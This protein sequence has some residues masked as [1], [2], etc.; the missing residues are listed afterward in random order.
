MAKLA[1][2]SEHLQHFL[3]GM[4]DTFWDDLYGLAKLAWPSTK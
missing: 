2:I 4:K 1:E 3:V